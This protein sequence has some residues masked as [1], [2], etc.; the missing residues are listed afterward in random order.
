M[1][2]APVQDKDTLSNAERAKN[3]NGLLQVLMDINTLNGGS[4]D[5][6]DKI[7]IHAK[8]FE[9]ALFAKS[10]SKKEYMDSM[11]EKVAVMRNT[12]N[13][14]KNAV[15]AAAANNNIKPVEQHHINNLKNS[16]NSANNMNV[17]MNLNPQ[18]N[19]NNNN[20]NSSSSNRGV[21]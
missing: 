16:G 8:N 15:T 6:A 5:T 3:V 10:S 14:R 13:T 7:R 9:A 11:N 21:N 19:N 1:S 2:A 12:Y 18:I 20:N 4:S 17:N